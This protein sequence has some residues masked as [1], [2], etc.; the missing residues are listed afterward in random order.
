MKTEKE[1][2]ELTEAL[3]S[4]N[5]KLAD[6]NEEELELVSGGFCTPKPYIF[7]E[8]FKVD[9]AGESNATG[10]FVPDFL[11]GSDY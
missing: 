4:L 1:L 8:T 5:K 9:G 11:P 10:G 6:L 3:V 7:P 2:K